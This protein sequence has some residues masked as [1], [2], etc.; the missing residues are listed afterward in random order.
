MT[1]RNVDAAG[2]YRDRDYRSGHCLQIPQ[3]RP[4]DEEISSNAQWESALRRHNPVNWISF[5]SL[6]DFS[7][8]VQM[9]KA[10]ARMTQ[11]EHPCD[12][13]FDN[14][15]ATHINFIICVRQFSFFTVAVYMAL[16]LH[17]SLVAGLRIL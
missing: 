1:F 9:W 3:W 17:F 8:G 11:I 4:S 2:S 6:E 13:V 12:L 16:F 15:P 10:R 14:Y 7:P 5:N